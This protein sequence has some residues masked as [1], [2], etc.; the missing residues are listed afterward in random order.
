MSLPLRSESEYMTTEAAMSGRAFSGF[1]KL[2]YDVAG[3][4]MSDG[5]K[6]LVSGRLVKRL[7]ALNI[8]SYD[9]YLDFLTKGEGTHNGEL[10]EFIDLL[11]T[12]ET[13][14]YREPQHFEFLKEEILSKWD[15]SKLFRIWC[16]ASSSG[17]ECYTLAFTL[18]EELGINGA[19]DILGTDISTEM[20]SAARTAIYNEHRTRLVPKHIRQKYFLKGTGA[21][22]G[23]VAV[24]PE[25]KKH[26]R[27]DHYNLIESPSGSQSYDAIFCRNVLIYFDPPTK[28]KV[29]TKLCKQLK[30]GSHF[31][32][33][34]SESL[35]G[36]VP[37]MDPVSPSV[38]VKTSGI[39]G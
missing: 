21:H 17:E 29:V 22:E 34:H 3:I 8:A 32:A 11:T 18:A 2:I 25:L 5:K 4:S 26:V 15:K 37:E 19:W 31:M 23:F 28:K 13:Y 12:N 1:Q 9:E 39:N 38:Y 35:H 16:A 30:I 24:A 6:S 36:M 27:I 14:F 10:Q 20:I 33:G 7:S